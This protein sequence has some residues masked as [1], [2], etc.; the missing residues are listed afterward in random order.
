MV[1]RDD[2]LRIVMLTSAITLA[3]R[4]VPMVMGF[5]MVYLLTWGGWLASLGL[6]PV[7]MV[8]WGA[9]AAHAVW[10]YR[11]IRWRERDD[12]FKAFRLNHWMA[13]TLFAGLALGLALSP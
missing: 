5:Y 1:D 8:F 9:A 13:A 6:H 2:D 10:H 11:L 4:D 7:W 3:D 12:C